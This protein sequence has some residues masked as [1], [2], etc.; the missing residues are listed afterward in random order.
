[1]NSAVKGFLD[2][3][4]LCRMAHEEGFRIHIRVLGIKSGLSDDEIEEVTNDL[5]KLAHDISERW[6]PQKE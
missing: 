2:E 6:T 1:M 5:I 3:F 4:A